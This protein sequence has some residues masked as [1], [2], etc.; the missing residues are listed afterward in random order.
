V[1][2]ALP[3][4][5]PPTEMEKALGKS[6]HA[7]SQENN[8]GRRGGKTDAPDEKAF[9]MLPYRN[10]LIGQGFAFSGFKS[11]LSPLFLVEFLHGSTIFAGVLYAYVYELARAARD[12][13]VAKQVISICAHFSYE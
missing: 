3:E 6:F 9:Q 5:P 1:A 13:A 8:A 11:L 7:L 10:K 12:E 4:P 2:P